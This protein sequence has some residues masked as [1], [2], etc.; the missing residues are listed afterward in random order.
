M[1][2]SSS[3]MI[4]PITRPFAL[5]MAPPGSKSL[6]NRAL[7]LAALA[8]G[9]SE[10]SN[11][12]FADDTLVMLECLG[13]LGFGVE[14]DRAARRVRVAGGGGNVP[15]GDAEL[16]CGN[17][18]TTIRFLT[19]LCALGRGQYNLDGIPRMRQRP[20]GELVHLLKNLGGRIEYLMNEGFPPVL[21]RG[22]PRGLA[23][24]IVRFGPS[25]SSQ[26]LSAV[27]QVA[28]FARHEVKVDLE[29]RQT[30]WPYV[31]MTMRLM[32]A[33]GA[34][35][36][37]IRDPRSDEPRQIIVPQERYQATD[38]AI[39]PDASNATYF[40]AA[41][42][43]H[44]GSRVTIEGLGKRSLQGDVGFADVL[45]RMGADLVFGPDFI[46]VGGTETFEGIDVDLSTMP[47]T[48]QTLAVAALFAEGPTTIRGLHTLRVKE[49]DRVAALATEL[50]KLGA[51]VDMEGDDLTIQPPEDGRLR[52]AAIDTYDDHRMAMSF[53]LAGTKSAGVRINDPSCVN[54]T[55]PEYFEDLEKLRGQIS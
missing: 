21:V 22:S 23:G 42:A 37:L 50:T 12:L 54:K 29:P 26:F 13:R 35:P 15:S 1:S 53:A 6:T 2:D 44:P 4:E 8:E 55:Y 7:V 14:I 45:H 25:Q 11:V 18:G 51:D 47:D 27:L 16:F 49:T 19:A 48:A 41:A 31:A 5:T 3:I 39:E 46:S 24:G 36:H 43:M 32:D 52:P 17:S 9:T 30:S 28:P 33:F 34:T 38:Y 40:L 10:L 20:I